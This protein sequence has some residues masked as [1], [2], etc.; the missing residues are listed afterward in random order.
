MLNQILSP[1]SI[2][3]LEALAEEL[4]KALPKS[5][6]AKKQIVKKILAKAASPNELVRYRNFFEAIAIM[7][8]RKKIFG[9]TW[10]A[11][12]ETKDEYEKKSHNYPYIPYDPTHFVKIINFVKGNTEH[13]IDLGCGIGDKLILAK[14]FCDFKYVSG[15]EYNNHTFELAKHFISIESRQGIYGFNKIEYNLIHD[16]FFNQNFSEYDFIYMYVPIADK[17]LMLNLAKKI[18]REMPIGGRAIDVGSGSLFDA[19]A[20][21]KTFKLDESVYYSGAIEKIDKTTFSVIKASG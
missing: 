6:Y 4:A 12:A 15:I 2:Q 19:I 5:V 3:D 21:L 14:R 10:R 16:D 17:P 18:I 7:E 13:F 8:Y 1:M 9:N 20:H 11:D